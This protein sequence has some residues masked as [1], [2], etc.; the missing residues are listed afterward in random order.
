[1]AGRMPMW[2]S[3]TNSRAPGCSRCAWMFQASGLPT[4]ITFEE[5]KENFVQRCEEEFARHVCAEHPRDTGDK[6][7]K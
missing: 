6:A 1:M 7:S 2:I 4:G 3:E 5:I